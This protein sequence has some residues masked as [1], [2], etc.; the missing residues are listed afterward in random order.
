MTKMRYPKNGL[1]PRCRADLDSVER[2]L[3]RAVSNST[4]DIPSGFAYRGYLNMLSS[5]LSDYLRENKSIGNKIRRTD[6]NFDALSEDLSNS[7]K[8]ISVSRFK[9]RDRMIS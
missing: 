2:G 5:Q 4:F 6:R 8:K 9:K 3:S 1:L 7:A